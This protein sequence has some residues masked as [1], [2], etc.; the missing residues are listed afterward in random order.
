[1]S[2]DHPRPEIDGGHEMV[3]HFDTKAPITFAAVGQFILLAG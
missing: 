3:S 1:M 2:A